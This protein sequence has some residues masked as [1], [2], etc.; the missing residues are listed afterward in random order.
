MLP[1]KRHEKLE[2]EKEFG[3]VRVIRC[4][5]LKDRPLEEWIT[6]RCRQK[7]KQIEP[8]AVSELIRQFTHSVEEK[9]AD[10]AKKIYPSL[11][12]LID[13]A[14]KRGILHKNTASRK[15]SRLARSLAKLR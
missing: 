3:P 6:Q 2:K 1:Q 11:T 14:A 8:Q 5:P 10:Q 12:S 9:Q 13:Q 7:G 15:K 4:I